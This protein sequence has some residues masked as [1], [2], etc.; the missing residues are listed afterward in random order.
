MFYTNCPLY[1]C[2]NQARCL[3]DGTKIVCDCG[4]CFTGPTCEQNI[5]TLV[6][7]YTVWSYN[8]PKTNDWYFILLQCF[9]I[10]LLIDGFLCIQTILS[11]RKIFITNVGVYLTVLT[12][13]RI[14]VGI[15]LQT[16]ITYNLHRLE[17]STNFVLFSLFFSC[18]YV[19]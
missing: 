12:I 18:L 17:Q 3:T 5:T 14:A 11:S 19:S 13:T 2:Q 15:V 6:P 10:I 8:L 1:V 16:L 7:V 4:L 9:V